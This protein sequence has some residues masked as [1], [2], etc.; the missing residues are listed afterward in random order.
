MS[1]GN[2]LLR[3]RLPKDHWIW[4]FKD[5]TERNAEV[6]KALE[7]YRQLS[8]RIAFIE[9]ISLDIKKDLEALRAADPSGKVDLDDDSNIYLDHMDRLLNF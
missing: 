1:K 5:P 2:P 3:I 8:D 6:K 4:E 7:F 9:N